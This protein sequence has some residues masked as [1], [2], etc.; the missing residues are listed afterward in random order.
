MK[1]T[2]ITLI[3]AFVLMLF[4]FSS[5][6]S[7]RRIIPV[8]I[9]GGQATLKRINDVLRPR[10]NE[11]LVNVGSENADPGA[12]VIVN[13]DGGVFDKTPGK[14][15]KKFIYTE[16]EPIGADQISNG[17]L[18]SIF[19]TTCGAASINVTVMNTDGRTIPG[20]PFVVNVNSTD[21]CTRAQRQFDNGIAAMKA[22]G[23]IKCINVQ[24]LISNI[25]SLGC[26]NLEVPECTPCAIAQEEIDT[27]TSNTNLSIQ[28]QLQQITTIVTNNS[29]CN[30]VLCK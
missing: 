15:Q 2:K 17:K 7:Q 25:D 16:N 6:Q 26:C 4:S 8:R 28:Q 19:W 21:Y 22:F 29:T 24:N 30:L 13:V 5:M 27:I 18:I 23:G 20:I 11:Y 12:M 14:T 3:F 1:H 10:E 9:D